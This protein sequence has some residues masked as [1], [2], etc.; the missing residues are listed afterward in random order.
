MSLRAIQNVPLRDEIPTTQLAGANNTLLQQLAKYHVQIL[1]WKVYKPQCLRYLHTLFPYNP[2]RPSLRSQNKIPN[3][4]S[5]ICLQLYLTSTLISLPK[6]IREISKPNSF[7]AHAKKFLLVS[8][9]PS[10][11]Y[12]PPRTP[13]P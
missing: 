8:A 1:A 10:H 5:Y 2:N 3:S 9:L 12:S 13:Q 4:S 7:K 6:N 11:S